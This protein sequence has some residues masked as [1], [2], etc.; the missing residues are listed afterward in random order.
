MF[1]K[2][3]T[4]CRFLQLK[5]HFD[6]TKVITVLF[7][8]KSTYRCNRGG[9]PAKISLKPSSLLHCRLHQT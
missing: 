6:L 2:A 5:H 4:V 8:S 7:F 9:E 3:K 1:G